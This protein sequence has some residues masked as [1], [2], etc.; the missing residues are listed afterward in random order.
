MLWGANL[1]RWML[2]HYLANGA[3]WRLKV[4]GDVFNPDQRIAEDV[5]AFAAFT[6]S[7]A[8]MVFNRSVTIAAFDGVMFSIG[9]V[10][11][12]VAALYAALGSGATL[13]LGRPL[14]YLIYGQLDKEATFRTALPHEAERGRNSDRVPGGRAI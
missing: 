14:V 9:P 13:W 12:A 4:C 7:F 5:R 1:T 11:S 3:Y 8:I 2:Q 6:P 10:L